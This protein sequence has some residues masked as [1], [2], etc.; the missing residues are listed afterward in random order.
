MTNLL[1]YDNKSPEVD[2][3]SYINLHSIIIGNVKIGRHCSIWPGALICAYENEILIND[4][5]VIM[6]KSVLTASDENS[7]VIS[8]GSLISQSATLRGCRIGKNVLIGKG[9]NVSDG[10]VVGDRSIVYPGTLILPRQDIPGGKLISEVPARIV[11]DVTGQETVDVKG[12]LEK[13]QEK[14]QEF[15]SYYNLSVDE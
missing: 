8:E 9:V 15:G 6:N 3:S 1:S 12:Q 13:L 5:V 14:A 2:E 7:L 11:R 4:N 10:A